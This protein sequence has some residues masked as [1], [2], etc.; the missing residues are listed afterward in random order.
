MVNLFKK[1]DKSFHVRDC[2]LI[3][4]M[5]NVDPA[6]NLRELRERLFIADIDCLYH[7]FCETLIRPS[8]DDPEFRNDFA[9]WASRDLRDRILAERL[10]IIN[11]YAFKDLEEIRAVTIDIIDERLSETSH[12]PWV[13]KGKEFRFMRAATIIFDT[14]LRLKSPKDLLDQLPGMSFSTIYY[15]FFDARRRTPDGIDDFSTWLNGLPRTPKSLVQNLLQIDFYFL[16]LRELKETI[17]KAVTDVP[18]KELYK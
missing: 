3:T 10:G 8:F 18:K 1:A 9:I 13:P 12:I 14:G 7:H 15:H 6:M 2:T 5:G 11:P 17:L 4:R 16:N